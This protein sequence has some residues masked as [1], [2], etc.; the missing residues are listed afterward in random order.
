MGIPE[1][2][3]CPKCGS[4]D[5]AEI[6]YPPVAMTEDLLHQIQAKKVLIRNESKP[7][8]PPCYYCYYCGYEW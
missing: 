2:L 8:T 1:N 6:L 7:D 4:R 3:R 5:L